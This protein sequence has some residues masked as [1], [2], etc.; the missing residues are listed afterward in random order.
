MKQN[1]RDLKIFVLHAVPILRALIKFRFE[2][3]VKCVVDSA[4]QN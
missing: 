2:F 4:I 3:H 1:L